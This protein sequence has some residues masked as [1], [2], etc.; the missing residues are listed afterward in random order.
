[1]SAF[2]CVV[3]APPPRAVNKRLA[4]AGCPERVALPATV[5]L[6]SVLEVTRSY[7]RTARPES[8]DVFPANAYR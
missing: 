5:V 1:M 3:I 2:A 4:A 8:T 6:S 7:D